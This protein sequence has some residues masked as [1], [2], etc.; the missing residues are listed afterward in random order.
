MIH[1][2]LI[3][4]D[5]HFSSAGCMSSQ[6]LLSIWRPLL[7]RDAPEMLIKSDGLAGPGEAAG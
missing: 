2:G 5:L 3:G 7:S 4:A 1:F 6:P